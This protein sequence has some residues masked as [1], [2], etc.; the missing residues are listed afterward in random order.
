MKFLLHIIPVLVVTLAGC[1][2]QFVPETNEVQVLLVVEGLIT[3]LNYEETAPS[4]SLWS[5]LF[6]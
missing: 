4:G 2:T 5:R 1:I 3:D 6:G